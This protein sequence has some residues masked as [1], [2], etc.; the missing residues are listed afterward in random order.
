[1]A[2]CLRGR[3]AAGSWPDKSKAS[4]FGI[5]FSAGHEL[6]DLPAGRETWKTGAS[7]F[8]LLASRT[9]LDDLGAS[10]HV[11][12]SLAQVRSVEEHEEPVQ[13][14]AGFRIR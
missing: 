14:H 13:D 10:L 1:M 8:T 2:V 5:S 6:W 9:R 3:P 12:P 7:K 4:D 11:G